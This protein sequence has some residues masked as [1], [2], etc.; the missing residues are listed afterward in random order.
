MTRFLV[1][2]SLILAIRLLLFYFYAPQEQVIVKNP[3]LETSIFRDLKSHVKNVYA[4]NLKGQDAGLLMGIVFGEKTLDRS[5]IKNYQT[6]GV[7]HVVAA[8]GMNVSM[9]TAFLLSLL[10]V[11]FKRQLALIM[12]LAAIIFYTALADFQ[13]SIVRAAIMAGFAL[14]AGV[15]GRQNTSL[16]ALLFAAYAM[17]F[18]DPGV[19]T[20]ISFILSFAATLGI[21]LF[22]PIF[23][24]GALRSSLFEDFRTT[25]A[26]QIATTPIL[27]FFFGNYS[28]ISILVNLLVLWTVPPLMML[29]GIAALLSFIPL[30][31]AP[32]VL[33]SMPLLMYFQAVVSFFARYSHP[34]ELE[35]VPWTLIA[36]YYLVLLAIIIW[37]KK[38]VSSPI[39]SGSRA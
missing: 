4:Q 34:I 33:L 13:P 27:L 6:T 29:G 30:L 16:V 9:L 36:G 18:W 31:S 19:F 22:D 21:I 5:L 3:T 20:S 12:T 15:L 14:G 37:A 35:A 24:K 11:F 32:F 10:L 1:L 28:P 39:K 25:L 7:L 26:A 2:F 38:K 8:S 17:I 23:K